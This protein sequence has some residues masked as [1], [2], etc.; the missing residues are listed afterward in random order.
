[1]ELVELQLVQFGALEQNDE[2]SS[3]YL[4]THITPPPFVGS[5]KKCSINIAEE[6]FENKFF[7]ETI[8]T[9]FAFT[10]AQVT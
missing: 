7:K 1:M 6:T 9:T 10:K 8:V 2:L 4:S 5:H 3:K